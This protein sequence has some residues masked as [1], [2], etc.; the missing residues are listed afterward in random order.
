MGIMYV[1]ARKEVDYE[2]YKKLK[3]EIIAFLKE[4]GFVVEGEEKEVS[5]R[6]EE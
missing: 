6:Y 2:T 1:S 5:L 4:R 3:D